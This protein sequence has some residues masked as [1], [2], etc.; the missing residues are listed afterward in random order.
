MKSHQ[1]AVFMN[2]FYNKFLPSVF[3]EFF[4]S[5]TTAQSVFQLPEIDKENFSTFRPEGLRQ[6][7]AFVRRGP[8]S[9]EGLRQ[10]KAFVRRGPSSGEGL[11]QE[12]AFV[13]RRPSSGEGL[14]QERAFVR[15]G[16]STFRPEGLRPDEGPRVET[17]RSFLCLFQAVE[18]PIVLLLYQDA[19]TLQPD[20]IGYM[21][22]LRVVCGF[23][24][25]S[26]KVIFRWINI[27][28]MI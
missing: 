8:S 27:P 19:A 9:G 26:R 3:D 2:K 6:E 13:R 17:S 1:I 28:D 11:R 20:Y 18:K 16:P 12:R 7:R 14:R 25:T 4:R 15:R 22:G 23:E 24:I 5:I 21:H 10:E